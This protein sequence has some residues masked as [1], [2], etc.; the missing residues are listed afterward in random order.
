[1][2]D[3]IEVDP[4]DDIYYDEEYLEEEEEIIQLVCKNFFQ[5][6]INIASSTNPLFLN[7][8]GNSQCAIFSRHS[9]FNAILIQPT[10]HVILVQPPSHSNP[11]HT[12]PSHTNPSD[13]I[14]LANSKQ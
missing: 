13:S 5:F 11:S 7:F 4:E 1:M 12:N 3:A 6:S 8:Q 14:D 9:T 10:N 2:V